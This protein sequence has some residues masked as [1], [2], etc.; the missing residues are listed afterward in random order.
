LILVGLSIGLVYISSDIIDSYMGGH[1]S[2][3]ASILLGIATSLSEVIAVFTLLYLKNAPA[4]VSHIL[5]TN[6]FNVFIL[7]L[8]DAV[9]GKPIDD[10]HNL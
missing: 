9:K 1:D 10:H 5:G 6:L 8:V 7:A 4:A 2:F 3:G